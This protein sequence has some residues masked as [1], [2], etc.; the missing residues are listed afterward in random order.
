MDLQ[1]GGGSI[2]LVRDI[3]TAGPVQEQ[4]FYGSAA[5]GPLLASALSNYV[6]M[7]VGQASNQLTIIASVLNYIRMGTS[8]PLKFY[9]GNIQVS[10]IYV[11]TALVYSS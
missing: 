11:G 1:V 6:F 4:H 5:Q 2:V 8:T 9:I 10:K 3:G 7:Q